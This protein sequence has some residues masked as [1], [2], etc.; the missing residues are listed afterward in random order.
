[1]LF[2]KY[3]IAFGDNAGP[4][5]NVLVY[6]LNDVPDHHRLVCK[7]LVFKPGRNVLENSFIG[8]GNS[9]VIENNKGFKMEG[10]SAGE[11]PGFVRVD[12]RPNLSGCDIVW[13]NNEEQQAL[14]LHFRLATELSMFTNCCWEQKTPGP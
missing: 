6:R 2:G 12:V 10:G 7:V 3:L 4:R 8:Y 13:E 14:V 1:M 11:E 5:P 9:L